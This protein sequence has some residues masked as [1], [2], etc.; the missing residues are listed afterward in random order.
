M[1]DL[2]EQL[3]RH[4]GV[5]THAYKD[6]LGYITVGVGRCLEDGIG[7]GLSEDEIDYLLLNDIKRCSLELNTEFDWFS[8]LDAVRKD[9][10]INL[11]F[12]VGLPRLKGFVKA[13]AAMKAQ[14]YETAADEFFD[15]RWAT[16]VGNRAVEVCA[17]IRTGE[18]Q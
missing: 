13:L 16:Q 17:M 10:M 15:S 8:G 5:K 11:C 1:Q 4:E 7:V 12:N 14:D 3:K 18:N 6:H 2:I 9:A